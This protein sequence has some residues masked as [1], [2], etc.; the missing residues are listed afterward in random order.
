M[1]QKKKRETE[2]KQSS[3][4]RKLID[5]KLE[6]RVTKQNIEA[7][8]DSIISEVG[9]DNFQPLFVFIYNSIC[10]YMSATHEFWS[11]Q[12]FRGFHR[13][14]ESYRFAIKV[15]KSLFVR[16]EHKC[17]RSKY[18]YCGEGTMRDRYLQR[19]ILDLPYQV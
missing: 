3:K 11:H 9:D 18:T 4:K 13:S 19:R 16:D 8:N 17:R 7:L 1:K 10:G 6:F 5:D 14:R 15:L 2:K 12:T